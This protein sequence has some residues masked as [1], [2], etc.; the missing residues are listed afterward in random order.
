MGY[1][2]LQ[3][4]HSLCLVGTGG[5]AFAE[6]GFHGA[7][8]P[9]PSYIVM[10]YSISVCI[11]V[12]QRTQECSHRM[13]QSWKAGGEKGEKEETKRESF[14]W[15][16]HSTP[17]NPCSPSTVLTWPCW[18]SSLFVSFTFSKDTI[19]LSSCSPVKGES[20]CTYN[21]R[22]LW[23]NFFETFKKKISLWVLKYPY[24]KGT[25]NLI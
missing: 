2:N 17:G 16:L 19:C 12:P 23:Q 8:G 15:L 13:T 20:G 5:K 9:W 10:A 1:S 11:R 24:S 18:S 14:T 3:N 22:K 25:Q 21:L 7:K 4:A 6:V